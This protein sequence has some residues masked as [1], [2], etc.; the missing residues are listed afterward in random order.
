M[1]VSD[2]SSPVAVDGRVSDEK[3]TELLG[4]QTED[5]K[6][7]YKRKIDVGTTE[8]LV[9]F[10]R[11]GHKVVL[12]CV[13]RHPS[14]CAIFHT[15]GQYLDANADQQLVFTAGDAYWRDGTRSVRISQQGFEEII[16]RCVADAK[17]AWL[18]EQQEIR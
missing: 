13:G 10:A 9:K 14:G 8:G 11:D 17:T 3:L 15:D 18:A 16:E 7:D 1:V 6:L 12:I 4:F 2:L 5:S